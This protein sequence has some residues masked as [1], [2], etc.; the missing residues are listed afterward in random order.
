MI[1]SDEIVRIKDTIVNAVPIEKLYLFGSFANGTPN[2]S[3]DYDFYMVVPNDGVRPIDAIGDAHL[4]MRGMK[5]KPVDILAGTVE[6]FDRRSR[7]L[8]IERKIAREGVV[9]YERRP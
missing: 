6:I 1:V 4:A 8:T 2:E 5:T 9:L 7:Q 3:S